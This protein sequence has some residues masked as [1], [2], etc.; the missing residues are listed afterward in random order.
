LLLGRSNDIPTGGSIPKSRA[1]TGYQR[2]LEEHRQRRVEWALRKKRR[3]MLKEKRIFRESQ[4]FILKTARRI[5]M[6]HNTYDSDDDRHVVP[7]KIGLLGERWE[8]EE[9]SDEPHGIPQGFEEGDYGEEVEEW[10]RIFRRAGRRLQVWSGARDLAV[11]NARVANGG[12]RVVRPD[13]EIVNGG[14]PSN[15]KEKLI[16]TLLG[17]NETSTVASD[18]ISVGQ[19]KGRQASTTQV[20]GPRDLNDEITQDLLA[21]RSDEDM[22]GEESGDGESDVDMD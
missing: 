13:Q 6:E 19:G 18:T 22:D 11:F 8:D 1:R 10:V 2:E 14:R 3:E 15:R 16:H 20:R 9:M 4:R 17:M 7:R 5:D 21:E 12:A